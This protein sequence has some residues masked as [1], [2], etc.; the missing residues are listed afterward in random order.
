V[1]VP[2]VPAAEAAGEGGV[3]LAL[4]RHV[5]SAS[6]AGAAT[7]QNAPN[8]TS[9]SSA[10]DIRYTLPVVAASIRIKAAPRATVKA[11]ST[12]ARYVAEPLQV[13][14]VQPELR[15]AAL[16]ARTKPNATSNEPAAKWSHIGVAN[17]RKML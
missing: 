3:E 16:A 2:K 15:D 12:D 10:A 14:L 11:S 1:T 13:P 17:A 9:A 7:S 4:A 8:P 6:M 5:E